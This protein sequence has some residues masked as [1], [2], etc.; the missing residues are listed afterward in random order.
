MARYG[1][2]NQ[3]TLDNT[4][5]TDGQFLR[6]QSGV[7]V[8]YTLQPSD[9][10]SSVRSQ[11]QI[12]A[13]RNLAVSDAGRHLYNL[14]STDYTLTIPNN[15]FAPND[16]IEIAADSTGFI[17]LAAGAGFTINGASAAV[18]YPGTAGFLK[19]RT[20]ATAQWYGGTPPTV[21]SVALNKV[22]G[23]WHWHTFSGIT[24]SVGMTGGNGAFNLFTFQ[25][26]T[27][28]S[29]TANNSLDTTKQGILLFNT[30]TTA[31]GRA[32]I[33]G[34]NG[35]SL[36]QPQVQ[37]RLQSSSTFI[38]DTLMRVPTLS[39]GTEGFRQFYGWSDSLT[40]LS[41]QA[42]YIY[43]N[44]SNSIIGGV[45]NS[46]SSSVT[47]GTLTA[48]VW[49]RLRMTA[50][51]SVVRF[52]LNDNTIES[53]TTNIPTGGMTFHSTQLKTVGVTAR[54]AHIDYTYIDLT[55]PSPF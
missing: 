2:I 7:W 46:A 44:E 51:N 15:T 41:G 22:S 39:T 16:E 21:P 4:P 55:Y 13:S 36:T 33:C 3:K 17:N 10:P 11:L 14:G 38:L 37:Q 5:G 24:A 19:F 26:G 8:P 50:T 29:I 30:G 9:I 12:T 27:G 45:A 52:Q 54:T 31:T 25:T 48:D 47:L 20:S 49:T 43:I 28:A 35:N 34:A 40:P 32:G 42:C 23:F 1:T 18:C 6:R 53:L